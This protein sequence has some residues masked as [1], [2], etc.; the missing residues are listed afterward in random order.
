M[1]RT[2]AAI[3]SSAETLVDSLSIYGIAMDSRRRLCR[4]SFRF[5][6][7]RYVIR[8]LP[9]PDLLMPGTQN[10]G[11][12]VVRAT[13]G[14]ALLGFLAHVAAAQGVGFVGDHLTAPSP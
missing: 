7:Y 5:P 6:H 3:Q 14:A 9:L 13:H 8:P 11:S 10:P 2:T 4:G 12:V 1:L